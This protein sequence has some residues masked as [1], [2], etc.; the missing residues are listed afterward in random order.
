M[1]PVLMRIKPTITLY[2]PDG[3]SGQWKAAGV[4]VSAA[5]VRNGDSGFNAEATTGT[6]TDAS[7]AGHFTADAEL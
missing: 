2:A 1:F 7:L 4:N 3:T 5:V 6:S